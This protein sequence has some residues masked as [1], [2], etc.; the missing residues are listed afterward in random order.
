MLME[1]TA[2]PD[3][4]LKGTDG[5]DY[6]LSDFRGKIV[7]LYF[8][9]KDDSSGC[10][11]EAKGFNS[12][13]KDLDGKNAVVLGISSDTLDSHIKF[14]AKYNLQFILLSDPQSRVI[15]QYD[16]YGDKGVFGKGTIRKTFIIDKEGN[17]AKIFG[18]VNPVGHSDEV[19]SCISQ[20]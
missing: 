18:K 1:G 4:S 15:R 8:Y 14:S 9:P 20:I 12:A 10:T 19:L 6:S 17:I 7:V 13:L 11:L 2:A 3:F 16:S 5:K